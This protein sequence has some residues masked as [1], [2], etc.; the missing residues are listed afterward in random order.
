MVLVAGARPA[1]ANAALLGANDDTY[2]TPFE[3]RLE[4]SA[5]GY[6]AN[7][8]DVVGKPTLVS[9]TSAHGNLNWHDDGRDRLPAGR[10]ASAGPITSTT[11]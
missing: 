1:P 7:D 5:P 3:T 8:I 10:R 9:T 4:V 11:D 6:L 2:T